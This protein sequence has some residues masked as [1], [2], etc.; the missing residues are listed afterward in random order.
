MRTIRGYL[1]DGN[2]L[3]FYGIA[4]HPYLGYKI[5]LSLYSCGRGGYRC[6]GCIQEG[7][8]EKKKRIQKTVSFFFELNLL[9]W[10]LFGIG[11]DFFCWTNLLNFVWI[12]RESYGE[13]SEFFPIT[14]ICNIYFPLNHIF[15]CKIQVNIKSPQKWIYDF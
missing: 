9:Q 11:T 4:P 2:T 10:F 12:F 14:L 13:R 6:N 7:E 1:E 3:E 5:E 8:E 15:N